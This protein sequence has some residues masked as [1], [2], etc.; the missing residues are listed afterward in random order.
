MKQGVEWRGCI[1]A[2]FFTA[3]CVIACGVAHREAEGSKLR[4]AV[5][6]LSKTED[7]SQGRSMW[8]SSADGHDDST[9]NR[10]ARRIPV[11]NRAQNR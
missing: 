4:P 11:L 6:G 3:R 2:H 5:E 10:E 7:Q 9:S 1:W 8:H